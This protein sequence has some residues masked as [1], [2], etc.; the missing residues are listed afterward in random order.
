MRIFLPLLFALCASL[1][2]CIFDGSCP[3]RDPPPGMLVLS[4]G[5]N[6]VLTCKGHATVD[7]VKVNGAKNNS[8]ANRRASSSVTPTTTGNIV[9]RKHMKDSSLKEENHTSPE[10]EV[11][12]TKETRGPRDTDTAN[13]ASPTT[14][15]TPLTSVVRLLRGESNWD[16]EELDGEGDFG[17][18]EEE[19]GAS[20]S[21]V[22][23]GTKSQPQWKLNGETVGTGKRD[24]REIIFEKRGAT[25]SLFSVRET[26]SGTYSCHHRGRERSS[27]NVVVADPPESPSLFCYKRSPSSKIRCEWTPQKPPSRNMN[28]SLMLNKRLSDT[29]LHYQCSYSTRRSRYW[30]ALDHNEDELRSLHLAYLCVTSIAGNATSPLLPFTPLD[31]LKPDP[32]SDIRVNQVEGH[33]T[34]IKVN[35][36]FSTSWKFQDRYYELIYELKYRPLESSFYN[37]QIKNIKSRRSYTITDAMPGVRY[38]IQLRTKEEYDGQWSDWSSPVNISSWT[39]HKLSDD[40]TATMFPEFIEEGSAAEDDTP[41][42]PGPV[43]GEVEVSQHVLWICGSFLLLSIILA[44]Y[45]FRHKDKLVSKLHC[46]SILVQSGNS[47]QPPPST[48]AAPEGQALVT[49]VPPCNDQPSSGEADEGEEENEEEQRLEERTEAVHFSNTS[50]FLTQRM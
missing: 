43:V 5:S 25:M 30:C 20:G 47:S 26:D 1:G 8:K 49:F 32:P 29:F 34:W 13:T 19:E 10:A 24:W 45:M 38:L 11:G 12:V 22:T 50:Y 41:N 42:D 3:R 9:N 17:E 16:S 33:E 7:G 15:V 2:R 27:F 31:I 35:W 40:L 28:C 18:D 46:F 23:R 6:L 36:N 21:R 48:P 37:E 4:S 44:A 14:H 39:A